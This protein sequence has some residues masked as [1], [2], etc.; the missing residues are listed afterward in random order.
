MKWFTTLIEAQKHV[1]ST[2]KVFRVKGRKK[3]YLVATEFEWLNLP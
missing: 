2:K 1:T 3:P